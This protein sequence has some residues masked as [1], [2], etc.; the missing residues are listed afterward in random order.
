MEG[1]I[2]PTIIEPFSIIATTLVMLYVFFRSIE[3]ERTGTYV[4]AS[5]IVTS[6]VLE[7][8]HQGSSVI[9]CIIL[10][11]LATFAYAIA[12]LLFTIL[13]IGSLPE[14]ERRRL[15]RWR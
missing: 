15:I 14:E 11:G 5:G 8:L 6:L 13:V 4:V 9:T 2:C 7:F 3:S 10:R 1:L 12:L